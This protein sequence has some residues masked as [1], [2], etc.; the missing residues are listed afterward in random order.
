[1]RFSKRP[2]II[3]KNGKRVGGGFEGFLEKVKDI[4]S[5]LMLL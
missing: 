4:F 3:D 5:R 1:M 2:Y